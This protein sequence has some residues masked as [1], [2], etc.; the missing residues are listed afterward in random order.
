MRKV[1]TIHMESIINGQILKEGWNEV[2]NELYKV[3]DIEII[4]F[5]NIKDLKYQYNLIKKLIPQNNKITL[6][7]R[8]NMLGL[9]KRQSKSYIAISDEIGLLNILDSEYKFIYGDKD[10][11][12][13]RYLK[14]ENVY[15]VLDFVRILE[16]NNKIA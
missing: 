15:K 12:C 3:Y 13:E 7:P 1:I 10:Y 2:L 16:Y 5:P 14:A 8:Q 6:I 4:S 11:D 9:F